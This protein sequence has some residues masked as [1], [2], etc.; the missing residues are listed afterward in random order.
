MI[1]S[2][3]DLTLGEGDS[4][5]SRGD[6]E[7]W[8]RR[9][10]WVLLLLEAAQRAGLTP[11]PGW[12]VHRMAFLADCLAPL[13]GIPP[14]SGKILK[15][16]R[17]PF[18]PDLQWEMDRLAVQRLGRIG[19]I[20][21]RTFK[22]GAWLFADYSLTRG[23]MEAAAEAGILSPRMHEVRLFILEVAGAYE[24]L[25]APARKRAALEDATYSNP[26][27]LDQEVIDFSSLRSNFSVR[28]TEAFQNYVPGAIP[29]NR[30]DRLY[31]Y[32]RYLDNVVER[33]V[34]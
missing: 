28:A 26:D 33:A 25:H 4:R 29:L 5:A 24:E 17:G 22:D 14:L 20:H 1:G 7:S 23:G 8:V 30:R 16:Q 32:F 34:G 27:I 31:L 18:Y 12:Q 9:R 6:G 10:C 2:T 3:F 21:H 13:Y 19:N 11:V 15:Y